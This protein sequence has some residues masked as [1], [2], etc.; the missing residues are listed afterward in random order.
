M[1]KVDIRVK[2]DILEDVCLD[3]ADI[4]N[5]TCVEREDCPVFRLKK[6]QKVIIKN[7]IFGGSNE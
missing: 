4:L 6:Y 5:H 3:C 7:K 1:G 2:K